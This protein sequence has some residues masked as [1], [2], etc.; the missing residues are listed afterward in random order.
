MAELTIV[1]LDPGGTTGWASAYFDYLPDQTLDKVTFNC[2]QFDKPQHHKQLWSAIQCE[3]HAT[4]DLVIVS[5]SFEYRA[6]SRAGL[7]LDSKEYI[8]VAK[9]FSQLHDTLYVEQ[10]AAKAKGFVKDEHIKKLGLWSPSQRHAMDAYRHLLYFMIFG[11][12]D[13]MKQE[14]LKAAWK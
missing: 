4:D 2:S 12:Y 13:L 14:L 10:T 11:P 9:L 1:A 8:G 6:N 3:F 5:E 7:V